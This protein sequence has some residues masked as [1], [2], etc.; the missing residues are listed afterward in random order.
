MVENEFKASSAA[1]FDLT[2]GKNPGVD[3]NWSWP[4]H[5]NSNT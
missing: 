4:R 1:A 2:F 5:Q 3:L